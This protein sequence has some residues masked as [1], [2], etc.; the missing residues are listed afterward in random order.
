MCFYRMMSMKLQK[1]ITYAFF[2]ILQISCSVHDQIK[3]TEIINPSE[4][5]IN[6]ALAAARTEFNQANTGVKLRSSIQAYKNVLL[7]EQHNIESLT[8][9]SSQ[10]ILLGAAYSDSTSQ[11]RIMFQQARIYAEQVM[12]TNSA[13]KKKID[14]G[15]QIWEAA[16]TLQEA[17][18]EASMLWVTAWQYEFKETMNNIQRIFNVDKLLNTL[19]ILHHIEKVSPNFAGG[20][21]DFA[22]AVDYLAVPGFL[23]GDKELGMHYL[24]QVFNNNQDWIFGRWVKGFYYSGLVGFND[25]VVQ[26][27][28]WVASVN[29]D[30]FKDAYPWKVHFQQSA[31]ALLRV[32]E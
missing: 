3:S 14:N 28:T 10:Y 19:P 17:E 31:D 15:A 25:E 32:N 26:A 30:E 23:G 2:L 22:L 5:T 16:D 1:L 11:K 21:V 27:L 9:L 13:F 29:I 12:L 6:E 7:I 8:A 18:F 20:A 4:L 24:K